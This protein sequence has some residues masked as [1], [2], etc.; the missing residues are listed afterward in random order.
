MSAPE[1][2]KAWLDERGMKQSFFAGKM[3]VRD[4]TV[5]KWMC[6][7]AVPSLPYA[8]EIQTITGVGA[9]EWVK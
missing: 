9:A 8:L 2:L 7:K 1:K 4:A 6:G 3:G 5:S